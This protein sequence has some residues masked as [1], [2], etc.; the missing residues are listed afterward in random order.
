MTTIKKILVTDNNDILGSSIALHLY[1]QG[2]HVCRTCEVDQAHNVIEA[3]KKAGEPFDLVISDILTSGRNEITFINWLHA[4]HPEVAVLVVSG[5]GN[6]AMLGTLLRPARDSFR[7]KP[8]L[9]HE[10][11]GAIL[12][13][14][15]KKRG[16]PEIRA[17]TQGSGE[18]LHL[19]CRAEKE[20]VEFHKTKEA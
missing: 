15:K 13:L 5:F 18:I 16:L 6:A 4:H 12:A 7:E 19:T 9:P 17:M 11:E 1:R 10:I 3:A 14:E 8:V 2:L 20:R